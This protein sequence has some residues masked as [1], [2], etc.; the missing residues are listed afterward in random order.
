MREI[1]FRAYSKKHN[2]MIN[3]DDLVLENSEWYAMC[4]S[5]DFDVDASPI[6]MQYTVLTD[7]KGVDIYEGDIV[8]EPVCGE[9]LLRTVEWNEHE[10]C[11]VIAIK[12][13]CLQL[14]SEITSILEVI[15]NIYENPELLK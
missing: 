6:L 4:D 15:G 9:N 3:Y 10:C 8:Q 7:K 12:N 2:Q 11:F 14:T 13:A 1:K 5:S